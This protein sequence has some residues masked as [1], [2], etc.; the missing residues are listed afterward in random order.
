MAHCVAQILTGAVPPS[1]WEP[2]GE[3]DLPVFAEEG[4]A[5]GGRPS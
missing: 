1:V 5:S 4:V 3:E 2:I